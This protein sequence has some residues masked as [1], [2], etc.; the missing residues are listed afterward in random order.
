MQTTVRSVRT[1]GSL[2]PMYGKRHGYMTKQ[3][4]SNSQKRRHTDIKRAL[5]EDILD[6]ADT[7]SEA[8]KDVLLQLL[9]NN[10]LNF[11]SVQQAVNFLGRMLTEELIARVLRDE[12]NKFI[13][14]DARLV[15]PFSSSLK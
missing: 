9:D 10:E 3:K 2:N 8:R 13:E 4:M 15:Q 11:Q 14:E 12:I 5:Q 1:S 7:S 6:Y